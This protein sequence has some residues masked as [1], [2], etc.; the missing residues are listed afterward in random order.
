MKKM[1]FLS[2]LSSLLLGGTAIAQKADKP[3]PI[4]YEGMSPRNVQWELAPRLLFA[5]DENLAGLSFFDRQYVAVPKDT[6]EKWVAAAQKKVDQT[7][8][9]ELHDCDDKAWELLVSVARRSKR[10]SQSCLTR[11]SLAWPR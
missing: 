10:T 5:Q 8:V 6:M 4:T 7:Y 11:C 3:E 9:P 1:F 2:V